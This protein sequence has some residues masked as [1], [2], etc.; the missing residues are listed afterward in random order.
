MS[1]SKVVGSTH[2]GCRGYSR[3]FSGTRA[4]RLGDDVDLDATVLV[5]RSAQR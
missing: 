3:F 4:A 1:F 5:E 2:G